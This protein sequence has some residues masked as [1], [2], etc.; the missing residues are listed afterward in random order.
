MFAV[1]SF[2][3]FSPRCQSQAMFVP[4]SGHRC[5]VSLVHLFLKFFSQVTVYCFVCP[6]NCLLRILFLFS[7]Q[8]MP[9]LL[10]KENYIILHQHELIGCRGTS[11]S[12]F[13]AASVFLSINGSEFSDCA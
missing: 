5:T 12:L 8:Y 10:A 7:R 13:L 11:L 6:S 2:F 3:F 1:F 9:F 4:G